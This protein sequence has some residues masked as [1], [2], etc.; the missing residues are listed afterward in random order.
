MASTDG[1]YVLGWDGEYGAG[2]Y[3]LASWKGE[4][5]LGWRVHTQMVSLYW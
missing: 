1:K 5:G 4:Y 3:V 2:K